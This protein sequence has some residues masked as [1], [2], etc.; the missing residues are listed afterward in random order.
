MSSRLIII[1]GGSASRKTTLA[2]YLAQVAGE[3]SVTH[4]SQDSFYR[5]LGH[6]P[7]NERKKSNYDHPDA[8]DWDLMFQAVETLLRGEAFNVPNYD[9]TTSSRQGEFQVVNPAPY[10]LLDGILALHDERL[11]SRAAHS[12]F[13]D[14]PAEVRLQ[15]R[16]DRD[17][18]DRE[19]PVERTQSQWQA[20]VQPM[21]ELFCEPTKAH[22]HRVLDGQLV[23]PQ[24]AQTL[25]PEI[26]QAIG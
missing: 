16:T 20:T 6:L 26:L 18:V 2:R 25:W 12:I 13:L 21:Y 4:L 5:C 9:F 7:F 22:A 8:F 17:L 14:L 19:R 24:L 1:S 3:S 15:S 10:L 11:R 23:S